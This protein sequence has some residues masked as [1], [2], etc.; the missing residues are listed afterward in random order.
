MNRGILYIANKTTYINEAVKSAQT[1][2]SQTSLPCTLICPMDEIELNEDVFDSVIEAEDEFGDV[3]YKSHNI[4]NTPYDKTLYLD[5]DTR[6][7]GNLS[8][9]FDLLDRYDVAASHDSIKQIVT[10]DSVP[11]AFP[12]FNT[13]VIAFSM[14]SSTIDFLD[15]WAKLHQKQT[16]EGRPE[17]SI[18]VKDTMSLDEAKHFGTATDQP[19]FREAAYN[20]NIN[21][22][23]LP[24]EYNFGS[25]GMSHAYEDVKIIH[26]R[27]FNDQLYNLIN[28]KRGHR[29]FLGKRHG[30]II[31][32]NGN[33]IKLYTPKKRFYN[34]LCRH[35]P[36]FEGI[37]NVVRRYIPVK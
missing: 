35:I 28:T 36:K 10:I 33:T 15:S 19:P 29:I 20:S 22:C 6:I 18:P 14:S 4:K 32:Q 5:T 16:V 11:D 27:Q 2:K 21:I 9:L 3:R 31:V 8:P 13:G 7:L 1:V 37:A 23:T 12:E 17:E 24:A 34:Y 25:W 26:S 30:V